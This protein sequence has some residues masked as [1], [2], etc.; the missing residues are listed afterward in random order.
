MQPP[1][2]RCAP[3]SIRTPFF[4]VAQKGPELEPPHIAWCAIVMVDG[5]AEY[6][7]NFINRGLSGVSG[8]QLGP[9]AV[10]TRIPSP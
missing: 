2:D 5:K 3:Q 9:G 4:R 6:I 8:I 7:S 10:V 1:D